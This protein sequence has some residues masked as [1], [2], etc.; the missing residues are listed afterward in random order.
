VDRAPVSNPIQY[1]QWRNQMA[2]RIAREV[3]H[4][5]L[6]VVGMYLFGSVKS[7]IAGP[8]SD[9]DILVHFRGTEEN[10]TELLNWLDG[11]SKC[12]DEMNYL[13][14]GYR[15]GGL[16]DVHLVTDEDIARKTSYAIKIDSVTDP[17][18][19]LRLGG[20]PDGSH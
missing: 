6:G 15:T 2:E 13:K 17:A 3:K 10:R 1:W 8:A 11:W 14:T 12:L 20:G 16:L 18:Q 9:I 19:P 4:Q 7:G 5:K